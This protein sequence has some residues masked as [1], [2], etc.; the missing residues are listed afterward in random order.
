MAYEKQTW[1]NEPSE[2]TPI[3]A[4]ALDHLGTQYDESIATMAAAFQSHINHPTPHK[5]YD[6]DMPDLSLIFENGIA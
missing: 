5:A 4:E 3:T 1:E 2:E 6:V